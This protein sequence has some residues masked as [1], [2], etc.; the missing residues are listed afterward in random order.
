MDRKETDIRLLL[1]R[2]QGALLG[3]D[4]RFQFVNVP[5]LEKRLKDLES[6]DDVYISKPSDFKQSLEE[7]QQPTYYVYTKHTKGQIFA[8]NAF[9]SSF[10]SQVIPTTLPGV[11]GVEN[12]LPTETNYI[13]SELLQPLLTE[14]SQN[15]I[16]EF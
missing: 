15:L 8:E 2:K 13:L 4:S 11:Y 5:N 3:K 7:S 6:A 16:T 10:N 12:V 14:I 9:V 1:S